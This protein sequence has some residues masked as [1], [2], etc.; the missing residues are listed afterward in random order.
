LKKLDV[1]AQKQ[2]TISVAVDRRIDRIT[3]IAA[4]R[5]KAP[6]LKLDDRRAIRQASTSFLVIP[7]RSGFPI[8]P[9]VLSNQIRL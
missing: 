6:K 2:D 7:N 9:F 3:L 1:G 8:Q 5:A 4:Y